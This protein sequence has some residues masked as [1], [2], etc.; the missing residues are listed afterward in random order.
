MPRQLQ[1]ILADLE[2]IV[3]GTRQPTL[4][5]PN[6]DAVDDLCVEW[7]R[8]REYSVRPPIRYPFKITHIDDLTKLYYDRLGRMYDRNL[9]P[10]SNEQHDRSIAKAFVESRM[11]ADQISYETALKQCAAIIQTLFDNFD[12]FAWDTPP[13]FGIFGQQKMGWLTRELV[14]I[15]NEQIAAYEEERSERAIKKLDEQTPQTSKYTLEELDAAAKRL[16]AKYGK[17]EKS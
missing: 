14:K 1:D 13:T 15:M 8:A 2:T 5:G 16:E 12:C 4:V 10:Y 17:E 3:V 11:E 6:F 9:I 7:L